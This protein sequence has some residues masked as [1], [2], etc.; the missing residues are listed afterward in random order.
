MKVLINNSI[1]D[2]SLIFA[3]DETEDSLVLH[4][5]NRETPFVFNKRSFMEGA[6]ILDKLPK[7]SKELWAEVNSSGQVN[8]YSVP[9]L[10]R[11]NRDNYS[12]FPTKKLDRVIFV[13]KDEVK[14]IEK[15]D[16]EEFD[17]FKEN[18]KALYLRSG[19]KYPVR[20]EY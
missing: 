19:K 4:P 7:E 13:L 15:A 6:T 10:V 2:M 11:N 5:I 14:K 9:T 12:M 17:A 3:I 1:V 16:Q 8:G 20:I 18:V